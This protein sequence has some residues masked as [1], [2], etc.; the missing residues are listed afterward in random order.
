MYVTRRNY[1]K[2]DRLCIF[3]DKMH[4]GGKLLRHVLKCHR[5]EDKIKVITSLNKKENQDE[6]R[7]LRVEGIYR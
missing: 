5:N 3:C 2:P 4:G 6:L 7:K 1:K